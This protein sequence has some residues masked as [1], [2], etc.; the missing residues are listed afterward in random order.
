[1]KLLPLALLWLTG[2][3][4]LSPASATLTPGV[5]SKAPVVLAL[6][7][8]APSKRPQIF[9]LK[10]DCTPFIKKNFR[11][12]PENNLCGDW[13]FRGTLAEIRRLMSKIEVKAPKGTVSLA[14]DQMVTYSVLRGRHLVWETQQTFGFLTAI[15]AVPKLTT[16]KIDVDK[17]VS[18]S[19]TVLEIQEG[20]L[21]PENKNHIRLNSDCE[22][23]LQ[24][25]AFQINDGV[26]LMTGNLTAS[27]NSSKSISLWL[28]DTRTGLE[29]ERIS[30]KVDRPSIHSHVTFFVV[31]AV[32]LSAFF[33]LF[34]GFAIKSLNDHTR[35]PAPT[36]VEAPTCEEAQVLSKSITEWSPNHKRGYSTESLANR[37]TKNDTLAEIDMLGSHLSSTPHLERQEPELSFAGE[38]RVA[39]PT[40][41]GINISNITSS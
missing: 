8:P 11:F 23:L 16:L 22:A 33:V 17:P 41:E 4:A 25:F 30:V 14:A 20:Y 18:L 39:V 40:F 15:P 1:M 28:V 35:L 37:S 7:D 26:L 36:V 32:V 38:E 24:T 31:Y 27:F 13:A 3:V 29:S 34:F 19:V 21:T 2:A 12:L 6:D 10:A 5:Y 9:V